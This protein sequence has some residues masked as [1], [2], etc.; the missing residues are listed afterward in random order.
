MNRPVS[1]RY[2]D[3]G[4][5]RWQVADAA[6][7]PKLSGVIDRYSWWSE[8]IRSFTTR[9]ELAST[10]GVF[11]IN[12]GS[13]LE[14]VDAAGNLHRLD[15][16]EGFVGGMAQATSLSRSTGDMAGIHVHLPFA[17]MA[18]LFR[19]PM[20][21]LL[22]RVVPFE[23]LAGY[24]AR[25]LGGQLLEAHTNNERWEI[26]DRFVSERLNAAD[27][28]IDDTACLL[29]WLAAG[30]PVQRI[31]DDLG[32]SRKRVA[33]QFFDATG[34]L[35]RVYSRLA[36]FERFAT[37]LQAEPA[38]SLAEVAAAAGYA[39]QPHLTREV[40]QF[41]ALTPRELRVRLIPSGGGVRD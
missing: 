37:L 10:S 16:G 28:I 22:N 8:T 13:T 4:D 5:D 12:L 31:A 29:S 11:I 23:D 19:L 38:I 17:N 20:S 32:W 14:I 41:A 27:S 34:M 30:K 9:R 24:E 36:R 1:F 35:P 18:R 2:F 6:P 7:S 25:A 39:D 21:E 33:K 40:G 15:A 3:D 26:L